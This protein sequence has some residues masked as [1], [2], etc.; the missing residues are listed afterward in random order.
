MVLVPMPKL[1]TS[2]KA[3]M[4][5]RSSAIPKMPNSS[6]Q[7]TTVSAAH[8]FRRHDKNFISWNTT[9][10]AIRSSLLG[11]LCLRGLLGI[12]VRCCGLGGQLRR[13]L[14]RGFQEK[15]LHQHAGGEQEQ[16]NGQENLKGVGLLPLTAADS[17]GHMK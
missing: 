7:G 16:N 5:Q 1:D 10:Q 17:S 15:G 8:F 12:R 13:L 4:A 11:R 2:T 9:A 6:S 14:L 3:I